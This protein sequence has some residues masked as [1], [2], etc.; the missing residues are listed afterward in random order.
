MQAFATALDA[1]TQQLSFERV[2][3]SFCNAARLEGRFF[4]CKQEGLFLLARLL[5]QVEGLSLQDRYN[6]CLAP[7]NIRDPLAVTEILEHARRFAAGK[8]VPLDVDLPSGSP[9]NHHELKVLETAHQ[10]CCLCVCVCT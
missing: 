5:D 9:A 3:H 1:S 2:L 4:L 6:F 8:R 7:V 10:V